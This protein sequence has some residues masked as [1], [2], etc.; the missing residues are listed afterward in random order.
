MTT[1]RRLIAPLVMVALLLAACSK[2]SAPPAD[3]KEPVPEPTKAATLFPSNDSLL[4]YSIKDEGKAPV[5]VSEAL[6]PHES[7][8]IATY[9]G[10]P[11]V[12]WLLNAEGVW[13]ADPR[14][15]GQLLRYLPPTLEDGLHWSHGAGDREVGFRLTRLPEGCPLPGDK[16]AEECWSLLVLR[17]GE[18]TEFRFAPR[19][20]PIFAELAHWQRPGDSYVKQLTAVK[21]EPPSADLRRQAEAAT[22]PATAAAQVQPMTA[23][24]WADL[25]TRFSARP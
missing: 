9:D 16:K 4:T 22:W 14:G 13:R 2:R 6:F 8:I 3:T 21:D 18:Q 19:L 23:E 20:G 17:Q 25:Q 11:Y 12:R 15:S 1:V 10:Q 5:V 7:A 24:G